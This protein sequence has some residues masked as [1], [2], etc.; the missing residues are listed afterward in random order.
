MEKVSKAENRPLVG[1]LLQTRDLLINIRKK[2]LRQYGI[3]FEETG[4]I[5]NIHMLGDKATPVEL[6]RWS[7]RKH[8]SVTGLLERMDKKGLIKRNRDLKKKNMIRV[9]LTEKGQQVYQNV[10]KEDSIQIMMD[11]LSSEQKKQLTQCLNILRDASLKEL[12]IKNKPPLPTQL[13]N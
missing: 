1:L 2:E 13:D 7:L 9:S 6:S 8:H 3:T 5:L 12:G 11:I 4:M 10:R